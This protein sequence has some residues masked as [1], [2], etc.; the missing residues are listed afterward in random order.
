MTAWLPICCVQDRE[1]IPSPLRVTLLFI[2]DLSDWFHH[3]SKNVLQEGYAYIRTMVKFSVLEQIFYL[4]GHFHSLHGT[5]GGKIS[6]KGQ[7]WSI[8]FWKNNHMD[9]IT[10]LTMLYQGNHGGFKYAPSPLLLCTVLTRASVYLPK[11]QLLEV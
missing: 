6:K 4:S 11:T 3:S 10:I 5:R 7:N 1:I 2:A 9:N 8:E